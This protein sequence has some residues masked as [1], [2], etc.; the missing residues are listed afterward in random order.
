MKFSQE[1]SKGFLIYLSE[2]LRRGLI[3]YIVTLIG[4]WYSGIFKILQIF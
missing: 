3:L 4:S 1:L 2:S